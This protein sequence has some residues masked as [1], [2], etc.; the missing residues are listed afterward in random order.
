MAISLN[1]SVSS[2]HLRVGGLQNQVTDQ[3]SMPTRLQSGDRI[4]V[5]DRVR[6][7]SDPKTKLQSPDQSGGIIGGAQPRDPHP[8]AGPQLPDQSRGIIG[9]AQPRDSYP[10]AGPQSPDQSGGII[11]G[12][13][14]WDPHQALG[15]YNIQASFL[16][17]DHSGGT[18]GGAKGQIGS[19]VLNLV[20]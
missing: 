7:L 18:V 16:F 10:E 13:Q 1:V 3:R 12:A 14:P 5:S 9:G 8:E 19:N 4:D 17:L 11:G 6:A 2:N 20:A 15:V